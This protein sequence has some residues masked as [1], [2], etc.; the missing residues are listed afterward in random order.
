[1]GRALPFLFLNQKDSNDFQPDN[2]A[3]GFKRKRKQEG[4]KEKARRDF[5]KTFSSVADELYDEASKP[6]NQQVKRKNVNHR[7]E[8]LK[9]YEYLI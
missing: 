8:N 7:R 5:D 4:W 6:K 9:Q 2:E 1:M 3:D